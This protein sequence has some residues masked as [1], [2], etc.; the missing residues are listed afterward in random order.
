MYTGTITKFQKCY[1]DKYMPGIGTITV[2]QGTQRVVRHA[3]V[4]DHCDAKY[5]FPEQAEEDSYCHS[6]VCK[7]VKLVSIT[8]A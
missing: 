4:C 5:T 8:P 6:D 1:R 3:Y 2:P 7:A